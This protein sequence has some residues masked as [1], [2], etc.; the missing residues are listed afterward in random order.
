MVALVAL[1][2]NVNLPTAMKNVNAPPSKERASP[3]RSTK[4]APP[5][6]AMRAC[7]PSNFFKAQALVLPM[8]TAKKVSA[9]LPPLSVSH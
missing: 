1:I 7:V 4:D 8:P 9:T 5:I 3:A 2:S 6:V